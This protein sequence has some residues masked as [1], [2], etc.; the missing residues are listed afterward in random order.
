MSAAENLLQ[1]TKY[2]LDSI[3]HNKI[4]TFYQRVMFS[5]VRTFARLSPAGVRE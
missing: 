1:K 3:F 2:L 4:G 5:S